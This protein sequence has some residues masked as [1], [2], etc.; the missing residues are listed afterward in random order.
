MRQIMFQGQSKHVKTMHHILPVYLFKA[1]ATTIIALVT[2]AF[3]CCTEEPKNDT[4][5]V[6]AP[7]AALLIVKHGI[8][9]DNDDP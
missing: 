1:K 5:S 3:L 9:D 4:S 8:H 2:C 6:H 7:C